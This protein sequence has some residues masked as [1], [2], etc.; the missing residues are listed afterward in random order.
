MKGNT[1]EI[2]SLIQG[3]KMSCQTEGKSPKTIEWYT[4]FLERFLQFLSSKGYPTGI[5]QIDK[6]HV[7]EFIRYLQVEAKTPHGGK[8]LSEATVQGYVRTLKAFFSWAIREDYLESNPMAKIP[9]PKA[10]SKLV[11]TLSREQIARLFA[12]CHSS[13]GLGYREDKG[14]GEENV[15]KMSAK[16]PPGRF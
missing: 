9:V 8:P 13:N 3:F 2:E 6:N 15:G 16:L 1:L 10:T 11:N 7:R 4:S 14:E 5:N 12:V